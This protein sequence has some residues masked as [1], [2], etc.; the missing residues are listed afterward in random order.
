MIGAVQ[1]EVAQRGE[2]RLDPVQMTGVGWSIGKLDVVGSSP[3]PHLPVSPGRQ[4]RRV[5]V[6]YDRDPYRRRGTG[7]THTAGT[8]GTHH[9]AAVAHPG[10]RRC[11]GNAVQRRLLGRDGGAVR[12]CCRPGGALSSFQRRRAPADQGARLRRSRGRRQLPPSS[13]VRDH[14]RLRIGRRCGV[15]PPR[16]SHPRRGGRGHS[17]VPVVRH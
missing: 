16:R 8:P 17:Q 6:Q 2:L 4:V 7:C 13:A 3:A 1:G 9:G 5:V 10:P 14:D 15:R 11:P 12:C